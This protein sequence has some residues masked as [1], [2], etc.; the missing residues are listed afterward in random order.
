MRKRLRKEGE[1][2]EDTTGKVRS[3]ERTTK[4]VK[5]RRLELRIRGS[6]KKKGTA[7]DKQQRQDGRNYEREINERKVVE[8]KNEKGKCQELKV[9]PP[10][11]EPMKR[12]KGKN[13][14]KER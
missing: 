1:E 10:K 2:K 13:D 7:T 5:E 8:G 11:L 12:K 14:T 6:E 9:M 3:K 4:G